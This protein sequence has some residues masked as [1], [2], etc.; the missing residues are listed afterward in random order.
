M[1]PNSPMNLQPRTKSIQRA[2]VWLTP[3]CAVALFAQQAAPT[4]STA[5]NEEKI[6]H[7]EKYTVTT[8]TRGAKAIDKIPGAIVVLTQSELDQHYLVADDLSK[9]LAALVPGFAPPSQKIQGLGEKIRGRDIL[10]LL[11]GVPQ[12]NPLRAGLR[13]GYFVDPSI[14]ERIEVISGPSAVQGLGASGGIINYITRTPR[15]EGTQQQ[16]NTKVTSQFEADSFKWKTN[17]SVSRKSGDYDILAFAGFQ[18][19]GMNYDARGRSIGMDNDGGDQS[20]ARAKDFFIKLGWNP[21]DQRLEA[22][23][24]RYEIE[25]KNNYIPVPGNRALG[26]TTTSR[27][28]PLPGNLKP[29]RNFIQSGSLSYKHF[30]LGGGALTAQFY[31]QKSDELFARSNAISAAFQDARIAPIGTLADQSEI[32]SD[33]QGVRLTWVRPDFLL[34]GIELTAGAD[35]L[36]DKSKQTLAVTGRTWVPLMDYKNYAPFVQLEYEHG[37]LTLRGGVRQEEGELKVDTY[38]T[39]AFYGPP[40]G[41]TVQG[42]APSFSK[43]IP[44]LGGVWRFNENLSAFV[45]YSEGFGLPDIGLILRVVN[46]PGRSVNNLVD[47]RPIISRNQEVGITFHSRLINLSASYYDSRA[48]SGNVTRIDPVTGFGAV[49]RNPVNVKGFELQADTSVGKQWKFTGL[50]STT[51]GKTAR[52]QG[53]PVDLDLGARNQGPDKLV[54]GA[55]YAFSPKGRIGLEAVKLFDRHINIG[56]RALN[57]ANLE[58]NFNGYTLVDLTATYETRFGTFG[59]GVENLLNKYYI[60]YYWQANAA[61][62]T[63]NDDYFA[64]R[65]RT[66]TLSYRLKF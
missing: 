34:Q 57:N 5:P 63:S 25:G 44:N 20:D 60:G 32:L 22:T 36:N 29:N 21:K 48:D 42:G 2:T 41:R 27:R 19:S 46:A 54:L 17:Y 47:L 56:R 31:F 18:D 66:V 50:Y 28:G 16:V 12:S 10:F 3:F 24:N 64:G 13:E 26:V 15:S 11:D 4:T 6:V 39:L 8:A 45:G 40:T 1:N 62:Q 49:V 30:N 9:A 53:L 61:S 37:P 33:K 35:L 59:L 51:D 38:T 23:Y 65:G 43:A 58:E 14:I 7:L 55:N 52:D